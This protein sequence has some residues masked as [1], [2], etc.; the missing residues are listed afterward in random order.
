MDYCP[1]GIHTVVTTKC[2]PRLVE[3]SEVLNLMAFFHI[4][5]TNYEIYLF[6]WK[7]FQLFLSLLRT[8]SLFSYECLVVWVACFLKVHLPRNCP[9]GTCDGCLYHMIILT[10]RACPI[11]TESDYT[12]IR[13]E[14]INGKQTVHSI[15]SRLICITKFE[16]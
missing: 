5:L 16:L 11:C 7:L 4:C 15:P 8:L 9:D 6:I 10:A 14:C 3:E 12:V 13:G 1:N 2:E